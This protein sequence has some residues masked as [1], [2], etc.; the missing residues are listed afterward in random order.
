M[1]KLAR[2]ITHGILYACIGVLYAVMG[3]YAL[4]V[5][6]MVLDFVVKFFKR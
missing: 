1:K 6:L 3:V 4:A 5:C 2:I